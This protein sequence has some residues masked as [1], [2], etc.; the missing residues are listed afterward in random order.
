MKYDGM[1]WYIE[2]SQACTYIYIFTLPVCF[3]ASDSVPRDDTSPM[4]M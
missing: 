4:Y 3:Y 2:K 1:I